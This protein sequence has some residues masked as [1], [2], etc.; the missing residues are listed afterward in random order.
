MGGGGCRDRYNPP[1]LLMSV[2]ACL[3]AALLST[4]HTNACCYSKHTR[5][6]NL[7]ILQRIKEREA[8]EKLDKSAQEEKERTLSSRSAM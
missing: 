4:A 8:A 3:F 2:A 1:P 5:A 6:G 7:H